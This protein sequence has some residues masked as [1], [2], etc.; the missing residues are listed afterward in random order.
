MGPGSSTESRYGPLRRVARTGSLRPQVEEGDAR[1]GCPTRERVELL[2]L[3]MRPPVRPGSSTPTVTCS[4]SR[5]TRPPLSRYR[6]RPASR[7]S[8]AS[9]S[10][11]G[12]A[13]GRSSSPSRSAA[14]S[15]RPA[16]I[17]TRRASS[18]RGRAPRS[19]SCSATRSSWGSASAVSTS[20]GCG[21]RARI[22]SGSLDPC[23]ARARVRAAARRPRSR[24]VARHPSSAR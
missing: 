13:A 11:P 3:P 4:C 7:R 6:G 21:R 17:P 18:T 12:R 16:C 5:A 19:R 14:C 24:R 15:P 2:E 20:S 10:T 23:R 22:R 9:A 8:F 1:V